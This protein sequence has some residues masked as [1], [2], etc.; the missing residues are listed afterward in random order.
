VQVVAA[1]STGACRITSASKAPERL[2]D[3]AIEWKPQFHVVFLILV[4]IAL[5]I[6]LN[7]YDFFNLVPDAG[8][9]VN[10]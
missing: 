5:G 8:S 9:D 2:M 4:F 10:N 1:W 6:D 3:V 7:G